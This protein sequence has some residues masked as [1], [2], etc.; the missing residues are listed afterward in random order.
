MG[1]NLVGVVHERKGVKE[2]Q[3]YLNSTVYLDKEVISTRLG[4][5]IYFL[6]H[7]S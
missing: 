3:P 5:V 7:G 4:P 6:R 2:F 1:V